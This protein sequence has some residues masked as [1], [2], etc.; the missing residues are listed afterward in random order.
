MTHIE[1][2]KIY[3]PYWL[4]ENGMSRK[5]RLLKLQA[6]MLTTNQIAGLFKL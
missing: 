2:M 6:Q 5:N 3:D 4:Y 1:N